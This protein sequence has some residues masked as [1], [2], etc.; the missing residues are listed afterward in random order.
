[1]TDRTLADRVTRLEEVVIDLD[2]H[3][4]SIDRHRATGAAVVAELAA[5]VQNLTHRVAAVERRLIEDRSAI[6]DQVTI[7][8]L[9]IDE[10]VTGLEEALRTLGSDLQ[11]S[12]RGLRADLLQILTGGIREHAVPCRI[13][14]NSTWSTSAVCDSCDR[15]AP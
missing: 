7:R 13:C 10:R 8:T 14:G 9:E 1:M 12:L 5:D 4:A 3:V 2:E 6:I 11:E 15:R